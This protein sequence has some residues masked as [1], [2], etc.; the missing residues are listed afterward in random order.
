MTRSPARFNAR[1]PA[2]WLLLAGS[3]LVAL[4]ACGIV[5]RTERPPSDQERA[6]AQASH[7]QRLKRDGDIQAALA[8][9]ERAI[10][11]NPNLTIAYLGA[12]D[13][14]RAEGEYDQAEKRYARAAQL[15]P[16][17]FD[18]QYFH[19]LT[20]QLLDRLAEA[21]RAYLRALA[22]RPN[23]FDANLNLAT[24]YLQM[25][26]PEQARLYAIRAVRIDGDSGPARANLGA[27]YAALGDHRAAVNEYQQAAELMRLTPELLLNL[28]DSLS[29][30]G[31]QEEAINTLNEI[32]AD[33]PTPEAYERMG[34]AHFRMG[35]FE[36]AESYFRRALELDPRHYP[37]M[38]GVAV[39]LLNR[40]VWS[41]ESD[42]EAR[43]EAVRLM[44]QSLQIQRRQERIIELLRRYG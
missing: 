44:R 29:R 3:L 6:S 27:V 24:A 39:C 2:A 16:R 35:D 5:E 30:T 19:G 38:N 28:A 23:D 11:S 36:Q 7:A 42:Q 17:N 34:A 15:E 33:D 10:E 13:I 1:R 9:F 26:E 20:L 12:G 41:D 40:Y 43:A 4:P 14:L 32:L 21:V 25:G 8:A 37:A 31:R 18:A 22:I